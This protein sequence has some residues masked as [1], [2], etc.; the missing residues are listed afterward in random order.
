MV[1]TIRI[2]GNKRTKD[3]VIKKEMLLEEG[4]TY[5]SDSLDYYI[6]VSENRVMNTNLFN[7]VSI[8][9]AEVDD[10]INLLVQVTEKWYDWPIPFV[11]FSD[12]NFNVWSN[13]SFDPTR[14]NYGIYLFNYNLWG[15]NHT[16]K[17]SFIRGYN[18]AYGAEYRVPFLSP[19]SN[20]GLRAKAKYSSQSEL[21]VE[22][23]YDELQFYKDGNPRLIEK[24]EAEF[25]LTNRFN[26]FTIAEATIITEQTNLGKSI[27]PN[28]Q[29]YLLNGD[30]SLL[31]NQLKVGIKHD[32]RDNIYFPLEGFYLEPSIA[33]QHFSNSNP[34]TNIYT[35]YSI[36]QFGKLNKDKWYYAVSLF[37]EVNSD[38]FLPYEYTQRLGY[39]QLVRGYENYVVE[40]NN[41]FLLHTELKYEL[42]SKPRLPVSFVPLKNYKILPTKL[43]L[44]YFIDAGTVLNKVPIAENQLPNTL[45]MSTGLSFQMLLYN[46]RVFRI[47]Y[48]LNKNL[49]SGFFVHFTKPI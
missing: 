37:G 14:T 15:R 39:D 6:E 5:S 42:L 48:S 46:D 32:T 31:V 33:L 34:F 26:P 24:I 44:T 41:S 22:T 38:S 30:S 19:E 28:A 9:F 20:Y 7:S 29:K 45:L 17:T 27:I 21:W 16:L 43:F 25:T 8:V 12:R 49:E 40:G 47:D 18:P 1:S 10:E 36:Q 11:E 2:E 13:F 35:S 4:K 3:F 23:L